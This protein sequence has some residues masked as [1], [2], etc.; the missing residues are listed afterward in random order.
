MKL[1]KKIIIYELLKDYISVLVILFLFNNLVAFGSDQ[2]S[3][4]VRYMQKAVTLEEIYNLKTISYSE[5]DKFSSQLKTFFGLYLPQ[6]KT[7]NYPDLSIIDSSDALREAYKL[8]LEDMTINKTN[9]KIKKE[10]L[11]KN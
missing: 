4:S 11:F 7:Y 8:K 1:F 2:K 5:Y 10:P 6:S 9:F 3:S